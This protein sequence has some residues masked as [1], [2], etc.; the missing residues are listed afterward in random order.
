MR[1]INY[2][3]H[4]STYSYLIILCCTITLFQIM[5]L[6]MAYAQNLGAGE[7]FG[8]L[9]SVL[10]LIVNFITGPF[11]RLL[12]IIAVVGLGFMTFAGR[13]S[14]LTAGAVIFGIGLVFGATTIVDQIITV[15][16]K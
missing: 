8:P 4:Q 14:W 5:G 2:Y 15:V 7:A 9:A 11:G 10:Q 12:A 1:F 16:G 13:L 6:H 3:L